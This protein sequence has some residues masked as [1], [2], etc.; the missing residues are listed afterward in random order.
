M[1][2]SL[3]G[4]FL[5]FQ[6]WASLG[7][8]GDL[9]MGGMVNIRTSRLLGQDKPEELKNFLA[10]ARGIFLVMAI[11]AIA[12]YVRAVMTGRISVRRMHSAGPSADSNVLHIDGK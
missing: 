10:A 7:S 5:N 12:G 4:L 6:K 2:K 8:L 1:G 3:N 11:L 9:G